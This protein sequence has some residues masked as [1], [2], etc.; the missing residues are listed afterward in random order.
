M[1]GMDVRSEASLQVL[2]E[3]GKAIIAETAK[4][5]VKLPVRQPAGPPGE[6]R[7]LPRGDYPV[8]YATHF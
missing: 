5:L 7:N 2:L 1:A 8:R 3:V 4:V 6:E